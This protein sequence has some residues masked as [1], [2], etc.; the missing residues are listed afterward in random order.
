MDNGK[1]ILIL[2]PFKHHATLNLFKGAFIVDTQH[3]LHQPGENTQEPRQMRFTSVNEILEH[4]HTIRSYIQ[5]AIQ[6]ERE[7]KKLDTPAP[8]I[9]IPQEL[10]EAFE[11]DVAFESA[12]HQLTHGRQRAYLMHFTGSQ[13]SA[14]RSNRIAKYAA[15]ILDG[16]GMHD[17][18]CGHSGRM[19]SCDGSHKK[20]QS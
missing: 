11:D 18:I 16:K 13:N 9:D 2:S 6:A 8:T 7:G 19:P 10:T 1:N 12:W 17:C 20:H 15:R 4:E 5:Q 3:L 14:T